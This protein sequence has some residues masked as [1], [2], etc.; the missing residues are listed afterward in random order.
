[1]GLGALCLET[2]M[3]LGD[4][5]ICALPRGDL[6]Q[7]PP[8]A[9]GPPRGQV[10]RGFPEAGVLLAKDRQAGEVEGDQF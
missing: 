7:A 5:V 9:H 8:E 10:A 1:M 4:T 2:Q 3:P 6:G